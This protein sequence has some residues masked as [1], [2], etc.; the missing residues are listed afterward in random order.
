MM[1]YRPKTLQ[2]W[3]DL[4]VWDVL[5]PRVGR[6]TK[7]GY[8]WWRDDALMQWC[9]LKVFNGA[10]E[11]ADPELVVDGLYH[12]DIVPLADLAGEWRGPL[13]MPPPWSR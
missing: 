2:K 11:N 8:F 4:L 5:C 13:K 9:V 3:F 6:P 7:P 1:R 12:G 10:A